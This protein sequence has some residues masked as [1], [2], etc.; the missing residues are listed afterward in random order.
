MFRPGQN[1]KTD[2]LR[3]ALPLPERVPEHSFS[4]SD[5]EAVAATLKLSKRK[6]S[7]SAC[8]RQCLQAVLTESIDICDIALRRLITQRRVFWFFSFLLFSFLMATIVTSAPFG[9]TVIYH[10]LR[11][12]LPCALCFTIVMATLWNRIENNA[13]IAGKLTMEISLKQASKECS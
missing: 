6:F 10:I 8:D 1:I 12:L 4:Y 7:E 13:V 5:H 9:Y 3:F 11:I 2:V